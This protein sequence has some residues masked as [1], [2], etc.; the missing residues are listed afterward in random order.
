MYQSERMASEGSAGCGLAE[1]DRAVADLDDDRFERCADAGAAQAKSVGDAEQRAMRRA[2]DVLL[3]D[4]E[5]PVRA[6]VERRAEMRAGIAVGADI[7]ALPQQEDTETL[8]IR[9]E[10]EFLAAALRQILEAA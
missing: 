10:P 4:V 9:A 2:N 8:Q 6:N 7:A 1:V 5:K 3:G